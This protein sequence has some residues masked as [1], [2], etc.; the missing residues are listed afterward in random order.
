MV[1]DVLVRPVMIR[2]DLELIDTDSD[3]EAIPRHTDLKPATL[4]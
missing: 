4:P 3:F 2:A 1:G